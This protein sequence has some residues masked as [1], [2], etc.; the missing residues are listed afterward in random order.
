VAT[1]RRQVNIH[2]NLFYPHSR[3]DPGLG[4]IPVAFNGCTEV[5]EHHNLTD[6]T[7]TVI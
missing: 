4:W 2:D 5:V 3:H 7:P 1:N 6:A